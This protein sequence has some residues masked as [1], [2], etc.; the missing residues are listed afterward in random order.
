MKVLLDTNVWVSGLLFSYCLAGDVYAIV[1]GDRNLLMLERFAGI[2]IL[3]P[4]DFL[5]IVIDK[6]GN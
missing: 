4:Q 2:L 6:A 3:K 5:R 1:T